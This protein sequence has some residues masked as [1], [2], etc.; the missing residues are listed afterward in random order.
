MERIDIQIDEF[1]IYCQSKNLSKKTMASYEQTLR[2][3][4]ITKFHEYRDGIILQTLLDSGMRV[5]ECLDLE[6]DDLD[7]T[8]IYMIIRDELKGELKK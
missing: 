7:L 5:G 4:W 1:M 2:L 3:L 8:N 6:I